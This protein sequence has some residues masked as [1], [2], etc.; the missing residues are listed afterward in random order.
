MPSPRRWSS[1][2]ASSASDGKFEASINVGL[3]LATYLTDHTNFNASVGYNLTENWAIELGGGYAYS[4]HT[5]VADVASNTIVK[6]NPLTAS[7]EVDDFSDLWQMTWSATAAVR[8][9]PIYGKLNLAAELPLHF[10]FYLTLG[11]G[12][13]GMKRDSLVYC[14]GNRPTGS[15]SCGNREDDELRPLHE[16]EIKPIILGGFGFKFFILQW[17]GL[18]VEV[19]DEMFPDSFREKINRAAAE[20]DSSANE[21]SA[22]VTGTPSTSPGFTHLVFANVGIVFTF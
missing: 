13:G 12:A 8:W 6:E 9:T 16:E 21:G 4:R 22:T 18:R 7:K 10:Q 5:S 20:G 17:L 15:V 19:R 2:T 14:I 11:G 1:A 3:N